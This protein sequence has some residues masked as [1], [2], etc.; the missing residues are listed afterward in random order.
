MPRAYLINE[1]RDK[2]ANPL[3]AQPVYL[4][5]EPVDWNNEFEYWYVDENYAC[6]DDEGN[7]HALR[8]DSEKGMSADATENSTDLKSLFYKWLDTWIDALP[9][10]LKR[11]LNILETG[12]DERYLSRLLDD[13]DVVRRLSRRK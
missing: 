11:E 5:A 12:R 3:E 6:I 7:R 4:L 8:W 9:S 2:N 13:A 10:R 1:C